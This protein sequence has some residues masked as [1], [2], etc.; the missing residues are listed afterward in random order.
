MK[1]KDAAA[2]ADIPKPKQSIRETARRLG[3]QFLAYAPILFALLVAGV[4]GFVVF[5]FTSA[6]NV[7]PSDA[8]VS[9]QVQA[10]AT[11]HVDPK[12]ISQIQTLQDNSVN[13]QTLFNQARSNPFNE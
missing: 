7:S 8:D 9:S 12:V 13:V 2:N 1:D 3:L 5:R 11:P 10:T 6:V 4:Y